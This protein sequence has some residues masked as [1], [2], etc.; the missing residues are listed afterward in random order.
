MSFLGWTTLV[1]ALLLLMALS[2]AYLRRLPVTASVIY[3]AL[4][5]ALSP[6]WL[7]LIQ[8]DFIEKSIV[9]EHL[10]EIAV[11]ISLFIGGLKLRLPLRNEAWSAAYRLAGPVMLLCIAGVAVVAHF[12]FGFGWGASCL[13]GAVLAPTD[14]VL[15]SMVTVNHSGDHDRVRYGLA[16]EAGLND[17]AAFP[18]VLFALMWM[19]HDG[20]D[21]WAGGWAL[22]RL[23]WAVPAGLL[24]GYLL[25]K[26][27]GRLAIGLRSRYQE[28]G[29]PNDFLALALIALSYVG[30]EALGAWGFLAAFASGIGFRRAEIS[31]VQS[32]PAPEHKNASGPADGELTAHP[33]A[34]QLVG[35]QTDEDEL[36]QPSK[37]AGMVMAEIISFGDTAERLLEVM[38]VVL[39]GICLPAYWD[40][41]AVP[42]ALA[43]FCVIRPLATLL[44]LIKTPTDNMQR[45]VMGW[46]GI[47]GIGSLYYISYAINHGLRDNSTDLVGLTLSV[48]ALSVGIHGITSQPV[49]DFYARVIASKSRTKG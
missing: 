28:T 16:G 27:V 20:V 25:G 49:L 42:L 38:M 32:D 37:A 10:T 47:R 3:L 11:I 40:W 5:W 7:S 34:E 2:S 12:L 17:G 35:K 36:K 48:V 14:P 18:F 45:L 19:E 21:S 29:A 22:H 41:R 26:G 44:S 31:I 6:A 39:V 43:L 13:L 30:A 46:F 33:P 24:M 8:I 1:G 4:G 15:A 9:F 23:A